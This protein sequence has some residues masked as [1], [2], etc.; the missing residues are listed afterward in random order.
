MSDLSKI[1]AGGRVRDAYN[2][3]VEQNVLQNDDQQSHLVDKLDELLKVIDAR[4]LQSKSSALGWLFSKRQ[5]ERE[6]AN[7]LYIWG[8][9]GRGKSFLMDLFF[10]QV[11][12]IEKR[13]V[14]FHKFMDEVHVRIHEQR[15]RFKH[16]ETREEDPV[17]PVAE[18]IAREAQLLCFD[19]FVVTDITD[20]ML[21][22]RLFTALFA[23]NVIVVATSNAA[24]DELYKDGLNRQLF[25]PF[26][27]LLKRKVQVFELRSATDYRMAKISVS[28]LYNWPLN[29]ETKAKMES[30]WQSLCDGMQVGH[31]EIENKGRKILARKV[32]RDAAR[33]TFDELCRVPMSAS[34]YLAL[35]DRFNTFLIDDIPVLLAGERNEA[36]RFIS[37]IDVLYDK[38]AKLM[39]SAQAPPDQLYQGET[40]KEAFE[41]ERTISRLI[42]MQ[43]AQYYHDEMP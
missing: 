25:L 34:D 15:E 17:P 22:S 23:Q 2:A 1:S 19:E 40:G 26:I 33:F 35:A 32:A 41:F 28:A 3:L 10:E 37:L 4:R 36:R 38:K 39:V 7:G 29:G 31:M 21:L 27:A 8:G 13:R 20:A 11:S 30:S 43:S 6:H 42:E 14:H 16:G 18:S 24:P 9:V 5:K 12:T